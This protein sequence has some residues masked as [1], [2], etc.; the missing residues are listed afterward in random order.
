M[1]RLAVVLALCLSLW[2]G[3]AAA[4]PPP[5]A[6]VASIFPVHAL[7]A[8]V[9]KGVA[10]PA[11]LLKGGGSPH[12]ATLRPSDAAA[13]QE[14]DVVF[15]IGPEMETFLTR[16]L[17]T[18]P[19]RARTVPLVDAPGV[20]LLPSRTS[21]AWNGQAAGALPDHDADDH[22]DHEGHDDHEHGE[23]DMHIWLDPGNAMAMTDAIA[24]NL[25]QVDPARAAVYAANAADLHQRLEALDAEL[26]TSLAPV[27]DRPYIVFHDA[28]HYFE[29]RYGLRPAGAITIS[30]D[31]AP[32]ARTLAEIRNAISATG[33]VCIFREPQFEP[34]IVSTVAAGM[35]VRVAVIDPL[36]TDVAPGPDAYFTLMRRLA[37]SLR[38][39]LDG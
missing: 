15:W 2:R 33:A 16:P 35:P 22:D 23:H 19:A 32:G 28:Y 29:A 24:V 34:Q 11:L 25:A 14:A 38:D 3:A 37:R 20:T 7:V 4:A 13:L 1:N 30:P 21:G 12:T 39:C 27:A 6:V 9:M 18:L 17:R 8:A 26:R 31:R 10:E 5:P 36:G